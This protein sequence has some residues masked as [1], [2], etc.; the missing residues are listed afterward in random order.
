MEPCLFPV[1]ILPVVWNMRE[2]FHF[3]RAQ[4]TTAK[5]TIDRQYT[6]RAQLLVYYLYSFRKL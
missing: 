6:E 1:V 2:N 5:N 4:Y 3:Q